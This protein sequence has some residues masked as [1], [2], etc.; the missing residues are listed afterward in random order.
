M[1]NESKLTIKKV[2]DSFD[3]NKSGYIE[4]KEL[5]AVA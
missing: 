1:L 2:F 4:V 3:K 5:Y